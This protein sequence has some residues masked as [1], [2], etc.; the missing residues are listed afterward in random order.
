MIITGLISALLLCGIMAIIGVFLKWVEASAFGMSMSVSG[1]TMRQAPGHYIW[2]VLIG[3][4]LIV[5]FALSALGSSMAKSGRSTL[6]APAMLAI[7]ATLVT[8][9]G[10][11][12]FL[13]DLSKYG[14]S[15][16]SMVGQLFG[17][18]MHASSGFYLSF[19]PAIIGFILAILLIVLSNNK[20]SVEIAETPM[21]TAPPP[22]DTS[23][24]VKEYYEKKAASSAQ[25][26]APVAGSA[27]IGI[28]PIATASRSPL[29]P[30]PPTVDAEK[31]QECFGR[32]CDFESTGKHENAIEEY[33][34]AIRLNA[35]HAQAYFKRGLL[36]KEM[37]M[38]PAAISDFNRVVDI[39]D[40]PEISEK[41]KGYIAEIT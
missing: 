25:A 8:I 4:I 29:T 23:S 13:M 36:L 26:S 31:A 7:A 33:T 18:S 24:S 5:V 16:N 41:A 14:E 34:K 39:S 6:K 35:R 20:E 3:S 21:R 27:T 32:A 9:G 28:S 30:L 2:M 11:I 37:G 38:R 19:I 10:G 22:V 12:W 40:S 1:F 17:A 15:Y